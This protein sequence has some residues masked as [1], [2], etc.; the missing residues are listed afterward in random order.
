MHR[1]LAMAH[2]MQA[3]IKPILAYWQCQPLIK[4]GSLTRLNTVFHPNS[5]SLKPGKMKRVA[6]SL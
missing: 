1:D 4:K 6:S 5:A 3:A 2:E